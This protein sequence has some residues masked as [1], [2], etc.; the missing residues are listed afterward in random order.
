MANRR[1]GNNRIPAPILIPPQGF[2]IIEPN[3]YRALDPIT[4]EH[5]LLGNGTQA[6]IF[7]QSSPFRTEIIRDNRVDFFL[8]E[9]EQSKNCCQ[10]GDNS[11][12]TAQSPRFHLPLFLKKYSFS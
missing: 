8:S 4:N 5:L 12:R 6:P 7:N 11:G 2:L 10:I 1:T 9:N 3:L